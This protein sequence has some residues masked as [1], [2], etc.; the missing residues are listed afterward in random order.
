VVNLAQKHCFTLPQYRQQAEVLP[1]FLCGQKKRR[2]QQYFNHVPVAIGDLDG[3]G[4]P[5]LAANFRLKPPYS[6]LP[7]IT[8]YQ[9]K[10][11]YKFFCERVDFAKKALGTHFPVAMRRFGWDGQSQIWAVTNQKLNASGF[12]ITQYNTSGSLVQVLLRPK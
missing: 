4:K 1:R 9:R 10:L 5:D 8:K 6:V 7:A 3:D 12:R 2:L 11:R